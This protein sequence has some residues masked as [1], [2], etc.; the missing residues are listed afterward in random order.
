MRRRHTT[1]IQITPHASS[2]ETHSIVCVTVRGRVYATTW[3]RR[4]P[5]DD[6]DLIDFVA[7]AR[8]AWRAD[9]RSFWPYDQVRR[10]YLAGRGA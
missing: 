1:S 6:A 4:A 8:A 9:R 5:T 3:A 2:P 7:A 10:V